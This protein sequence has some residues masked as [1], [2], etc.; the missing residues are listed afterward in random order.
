MELSRDRNFQGA[1]TFKG[2][3]LS[4]GRNSTVSGFYSQVSLQSLYEYGY[5][6]PHGFF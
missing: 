1:G 5:N 2:Q 3:E 6:K 4:R